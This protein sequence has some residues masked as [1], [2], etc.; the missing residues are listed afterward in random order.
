MRVIR[1]GAKEQL[2]KNSS[3]VANKGQSQFLKVDHDVTNIFDQSKTQTAS[4]AA[5]RRLLFF[6]SRRERE[7]TIECMAR[8]WG[9]IHKVIDGP[10]DEMPRED[11]NYK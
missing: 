5:K 11:Q 6:H 8:S 2:K 7:N 3:P 1:S 9:V 10:G 4:V